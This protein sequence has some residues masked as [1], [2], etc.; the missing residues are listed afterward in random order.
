MREG[1]L[2]RST[3]MLSVLEHIN[4]FLWGGPVLLFLLFVHLYFT[5]HTR[6]I[7]RKLP[8]AL[9]LSLRKESGAGD[10]S[11][12]AS[13]ATLL[14]A[15]LGTGNIVG[16]ST[17]IAYGG[18]GAVF[19]CWITGVLGMATSYAECYL[20]IRFRK[21]QP[22]GS[23]LGGPMYVWEDGLHRKGMA[24]LFCYFTLAASFGVGCST[25]ARAVTEATT[26]LWDLPL[27]PVG[28]LCAGIVGLVLL[29]GAKSIGKICSLLVPCMGIFYLAACGVLLVI[30]RKFLLD[31]LGL[32]M[33]SAFS[34]R[35]VTGGI[36]GSSFLLAARYGIA[37]GLFTNEAGLGSAPIAAASSSVSTPETQSLVM[38]SATFWDTVVM[39]GI[40]GLV[41]VSTYLKQPSLFLGRTAGDYTAAAFSTLPFAGDTLLG[42]AIIAFAIATLI[43]WSF[44]GEKATEYLFGT[45]GTV[46]Y[47]LC[48]VFM[49]FVGSQLSLRLVWELCD[50]LNALMAIPNLLSLLL[51]RKLVKT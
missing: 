31:A 50:F 35:S 10:M 43:G 30:N 23:Y 34:F 29:G 39:C 22:N 9:K 13:L 5:L 32:I 3:A 25:Q 40:T 42:I 27:L 47:R 7:Q 37:R 2:C 26:S 51:L 24:K 16:V 1:G 48:Y 12:F 20:G 18:P 44:F 19:W 49:I 28:L 33:K 46:T 6:F 38:M 4:A 8:R 41:I 11:R 17:A 14:A 15:T 21:K 36:L 45:S